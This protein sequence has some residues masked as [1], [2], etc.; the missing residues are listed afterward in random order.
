MQTTIIP[1]AVVLAIICGS[2]TYAQTPAIQPDVVMTLLSHRSGYNQ[3]YQSR[4]DGSQE[5]PI[6]GGPIA[7]GPTLDDSYTIFRNH[8]GQIK[9][10]TA[11]T[12]PPGST[13]SVNLAPSG[14]AR[15]DQCSS[16]VILKAIGPAL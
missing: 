14:K 10:R 5:K 7:E 13:K 11:S 1:C 4:P 16:W 3:L 15:Y 6:F 8:A 12:L 2:F 9:A